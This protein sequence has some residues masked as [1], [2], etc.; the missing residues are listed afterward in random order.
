LLTPVALP[1]AAAPSFLVSGF[2][3]GADFGGL[4]I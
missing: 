4:A 3:A 1:F 2:L